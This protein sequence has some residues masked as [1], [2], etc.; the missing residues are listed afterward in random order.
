MK[1]RNEIKRFFG[2]RPQNDR[3]RE[4]ITGNEPTCVALQGDSKCNVGFTLAEVLITIAIIG[5]VAALT[6]PTLVSNFNAKI[7][8]SRIQNIKQKLSES[9]DSMAV[10]SGLTGYSSTA[11]F[12]GE[13]QKYMKITTVCANDDLINCWPTN[14][15]TNKMG[16]TLKI[17]DN[18]SYES[19]KLTNDSDHDWAEPVGILTSDGV[20]IVLTYNKKCSI[21]P[22]RNGFAYDH[23]NAT[24]N[25][26]ECIAAAF[27][28][29]GA[30][31]PNELGDDIQALGKAAGLSGKCVL[32]TDTICFAGPPQV[33]QGAS[34][35]LCKEKQSILGIKVCSP[36]DPKND[37]WVGAVNECG[38]IDYM[39]S[40]SELAE[41]AKEL[42]GGVDISETGWT[43]NVLYDES[44]AKKLGFPSMDEPFVV[45]TN[46]ESNFETS[47][48][49]SFYKEKTGGFISDDWNV[50]YR[51]YS[52][53]LVL[54]KVKL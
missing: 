15:F 22:T 2:L 31:A 38:G 10:M 27:D 1:K 36:R 11:K 52:P 13:L 25:S 39:V 3:Q 50:R 45:W 7:K 48:Y 19:M 35:E 32:G 46:S 24:S 17:S 44:K 8:D 54:C 53:N 43:E 9:M 14:E 30:N 18:T 12:V 16:D 26:L 28:W 41:I 40:P 29:N 42:Y 47:R 6:I 33:S 34:P 21:D 49:R 5:V 23:T 37:Y 4:C 51:H 20:N